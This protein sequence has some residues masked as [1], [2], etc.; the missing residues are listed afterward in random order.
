M[1]DDDDAAA[2]RRRRRS[3]GTDGISVLPE[4]LQH[5]VFSRVGDVKALFKLAVTCRGWLRRFTDR[6]FLRELCPGSQGS[7]SG[8]RARLLGVV[9]QDKWFNS[10]NK[11]MVQARMTTMAAP[12][13]QQR[14]SSSALAPVFLP[15][16]GSPLGPAGRALTSFVGG[17]DDDGTFDYAEPLAARR[18]IVLLWL[19]P[20]TPEEMED[21]H[22]F[23]VCNPV[24]GYRHVLPPLECSRRLVG[25]RLV[26]YAI[27]TAADDSSV[28]GRPA[29]WTFS[30]LLVITQDGDLT[31]G[32]VDSAYLHSYSAATRRW[33]APTRCLDRCVFSLVGARSA[34]VHR[35]AAHWLCVDDGHRTWRRRPGGGRGDGDDHQLYR[36]SVEVATARVSLKRLPVRVGG[37]QLLCVNGDGRLAVASVYPLHVTVWTQP[38]GGAGDDDDDDDDTT[39]AVAAVWPRTSFRIAPQQH[40]NDRW[41]N[42]NHGS[43]LAL[44][45]G[46]GVFILDLDTKVMEKVFILDLDNKGKRYVTCVPYEMDLVEFFTLQLGGIR[47]RLGTTTIPGTES[48]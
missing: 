24:T 11:A 34:V 27:I 29:R 46:S 7:G 37:K 31:R 15:A 10:G 32:E 23:G 26:G 43:L 14:A 13:P 44:F 36:L 25:C 4:H 41:C 38:P 22:L 5:E 47:E 45:R 9:V 48:P 35:G 28:N 42:F 40:H 18:G 6:A 12:P 19:A 33:S 20:R 8:H 16:L 17:G 2:K 21:R 39:P 30:Q 1:A 3:T